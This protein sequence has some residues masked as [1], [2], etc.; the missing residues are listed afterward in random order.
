MTEP[1]YLDKNENEYGESVVLVCASMKVAEQ[2]RSEFQ[3]RAD[4]DLDP[5]EW[6]GTYH[7]VKMVPVSV[8][9]MG[10]E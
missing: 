4:S 9:D 10:K 3:S 1:V 8:F 6:Y 2:Y 7:I 5:E